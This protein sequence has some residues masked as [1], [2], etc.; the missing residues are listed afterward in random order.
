MSTPVTNQNDKLIQLK[1]AAELFDSALEFDD[2]GSEA[3]EQWLQAL[4]I[5]QP[6]V[7]QHLRKLLLAHQRANE[8]DFLDRTISPDSLNMASTDAAPAKAVSM[9]MGPYQLIRQIGEGGMGTVWLAER[10]YNNF[11][12]QVAIKRLHTTMRR[13]EH[14]ARLLHEAAILSKLDHPSIARLYD[15]G[16]TNEGEPYLAL[17]LID[18]EPI[19]SYCDRLRLDVKSRVSLVLQVCDA[20]TFLHQHSVIHRD[21]KPTNVMVD[22]SG[23]VKLL[24][25]GISKL[26]AETS[27]IDAQTKSSVN[28][29]TPEYASPEQIS[30][31]TLTTAS[32]VYSLGVLLYRLLTGVRPYGRTLPSILIAS[33]I[34]NTLPSKPSTLF[35][36]TAKPTGELSAEE[37]LKITEARQ[38]SVKQLHA[39]L[40][41]DLDNILLMALEKNVERRYK[42]VDAFQSD[43]VAWLASR[44]I[45]AKR[46]S[47]LYVLRKFTERHRGGVAVSLLTMACL[48]VAITFG[49]WQ[50]R[51]AQI[52]AINTKRVLTFLQTLIAEANPNKT[53]V[54]TITVLDLLQRAPIVAKKQFPNDANLQYEVLKPIERILRDLEAAGALAPVE[55]AMIKLLPTLTNV[56]IEEETELRNEY[57]LT[58]AYL[59]KQALAE[60]AVDDAL[61]RLIE[62]NKKESVPYALAMLTKAQML[63]YRAKYLEAADIALSQHTF[64]MANLAQDNPLRAK[65]THNVLDILLSADRQTIASDIAERY[66]TNT[67]IDAVPEAKDRLQYKVMQG[68]I[69]WYSG[70]PRVAEAHYAALL[71]QLKVFFGESNVVYPQLLLITAQAAIEAGSYTNAI[72]HL[73]TAS[74]IERQSAHPVARKSIN[75]L[76]YQTLAYLHMGQVDYAADKLNQATTLIEK[77]NVGTPFYWRA[78][79]VEAMQRAAWAPA[80]T[81]LEKWQQALPG[82]TSDNSIAVSMIQMDRANTFRLKGDIEAALALA[83]TAIVNIQNIL[84]ANHFWRAS[85]ETRYAQ[86]LLLAGIKTDAL[87]IS[88]KASRVI[89]Q[90][91]GQNHPLTQQSQLIRAQIEFQLGDKNA[92]ERIAEIA[93]R[94]EAIQKRKMDLS[95]RLLH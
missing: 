3:R 29:F 48:I 45:V 62:V 54:E 10:A 7:A 93:R 46:Q 76:T 38:S 50:A 28:A 30:G 14:E 13:A 57:A 56:S 35:K 75:I 59:G 53:G 16:F 49:V 32:D 88:T 74:D 36:P 78:V 79:Y 42:T 64:L 43:L 31:E 66:F 25:F 67:I 39:S 71:P 61:K 87:A 95:V 52:E 21:I 27:P 82:G 6:I 86:I 18:G 22:K 2:V 89:E 69:L 94:Y 40:R 20:L 91:L 90:S 84:P 33:A 80:L 24:D 12:R 23:Q 60:A 72:Q 44:P 34:V 73:D 41:N 85:A 4:D 63:M 17:E 77:G 68:S 65:V 47:S 51:Q 19:T 58:L 9:T 5:S 11:T 92:T 1:R 55:Q 26:V 70:N 15:A 37:L 8:I 81:A 83:K